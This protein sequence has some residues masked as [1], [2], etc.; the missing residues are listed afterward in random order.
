MEVDVFPLAD[1]DRSILIDGAIG[2]RSVFHET[3]GYYAHGV[4]TQTAVLPAGWRERLV[5]V[6]NENTRG[7]TGWCLEPHDL[8]V[9]KMVAGRE[10]DWIFLQG[11][12]ELG[13]LDLEILKARLQ[14]TVLP[15]AQRKELLEVRIAR[16][17]GDR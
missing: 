1:P 8:A 3:F 14:E 16:I 6:K 7:N 13:I 2:E 11:M 15:L 10:K 4:N 12:H 5:P 9:S 17:V